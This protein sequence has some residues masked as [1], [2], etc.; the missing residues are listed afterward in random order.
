MTKDLLEKDKYEHAKSYEAACAYKG[1]KPLTIEDFNFI[2]EIDH[3]ERQYMFSI[4]KIRMAVSILNGDWKYDFISGERGWVPVHMVLA[5]GFVFSD[6]SYGNWLA[7]TRVGARL[8]V[9]T[10]HDSDFLGK[11]YLED[12]RNIKTYTR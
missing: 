1:V 4:H 8:C 6:S 7:T 9:K 11:N 5:S 10:E 3:G 12:Y 2:T